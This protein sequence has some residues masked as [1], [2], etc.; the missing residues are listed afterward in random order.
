MATHGGCDL[1]CGQHLRTTGPGCSICRRRANCTHH[2]ISHQPSR[3]IRVAPSLAASARPP[4]H[5]DRVPYAGAV[6]LCPAPFICGVAAD[7]LVGPGD[8]LC[9]SGLRHRH[10]RVHSSSDS[11]RGTRARSI[12]WRVCQVSPPGADDSA[13]R[14]LQARRKHRS[15]PDCCEAGGLTCLRGWDCEGAGEAVQNC[16]LT[17]TRNTAKFAF[18][19][20]LRSWLLRILIDEARKFSARKR[21]HRQPLPNWSFR[22]NASSGVGP[23]PAAVC[24]AHSQ[25]AGVVSSGC[26]S[27]VPNRTV[28]SAFP[29]LI[30]TSFRVETGNRPR[31]IGS[32]SGIKTARTRNTTIFRGGNWLGRKDSNLH[33][34]H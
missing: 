9:T 24:T 33:H 20:A 7:V 15:A 32:A 2:D 16:L 30:D 13:C 21:A 8:D 3:S 31:N 4:L 12:S 5:R 1:E 23:A 26:L 27:L 6:P 17:A 34:P 25:R 29:P 28:R 22:K 11:I 18:A 14:F 19:G 10:D